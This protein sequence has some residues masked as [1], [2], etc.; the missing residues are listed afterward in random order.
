[1]RKIKQKESADATGQGGGNHLVN[2]LLGST[3]R[4][5]SFV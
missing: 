5:W 3:E 2:G 4:S 1:M